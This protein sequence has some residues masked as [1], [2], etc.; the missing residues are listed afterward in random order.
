MCWQKRLC[1]QWHIHSY[2]FPGHIPWAFVIW[3]R[4]QPHISAFGAAS[5][6]FILRKRLLLCHDTVHIWHPCLTPLFLSL[7]CLLD[8]KDQFYP[9][10]M[11]PMS[12]NY[13]LGG[14]ILKIVHMLLHK[15]HQLIHT[16]GVCMPNA[17]LFH[18]WQGSDMTGTDHSFHSLSRVEHLWWKPL[19]CKVEEI[20]HLGPYKFCRVIFTYEHMLA[21]DRHGN[22][23][24]G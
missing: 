16:V 13:C 23:K 20:M 14:Q 3:G 12:R 6:F 7:F 18:D 21:S 4:L 1:N 19:V 24:S 9:W 5:M 11:F 15:V 8:K 17:G 22:L 10:F 2:S